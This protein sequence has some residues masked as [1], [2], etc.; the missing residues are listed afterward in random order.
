MKSVA[1]LEKA[2]AHQKAYR[3]KYPE[4]YKGYDLKKHYGITLDQYTTLLKEQNG[5]CA[6]CKQPEFA[7]DH[8]TGK[9]RSLAVDH[10]HT[11]GRIRGLLCTNCN[12]AVG[13]LKDDSELAR[14]CEEYLLKYRPGA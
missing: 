6:I 14:K 2:N 10:N 5:V 9:L 4:R 8:R 13:H 11:T 7:R 1:E 3:K 12:K